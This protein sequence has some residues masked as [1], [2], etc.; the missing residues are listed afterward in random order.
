VSDEQ[1]VN[2]MGR[3]QVGVGD[4]VG[5][6][7]AQK[8]WRAISRSR[9]G[10]ATGFGTGAP[11][12]GQLADERVHQRVRLVGQR[13]LRRGKGRNLG[14]EQLDALDRF[15]QRLNFVDRTGRQRR[16]GGPTVDTVSQRFMHDGETLTSLST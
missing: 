7:A 16:V 6:P 5:E 12:C 1:H 10:T 9:H 14:L 4:R 15:T 3:D 8:G 13:Q 11:V 2:A